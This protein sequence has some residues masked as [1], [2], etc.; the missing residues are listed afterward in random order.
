MNNDFIVTEVLM[1]DRFDEKSTYSD[2]LDP[3]GMIL[4]PLIFRFQTI[5]QAGAL[6][7]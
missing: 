6:K 5:F 2:V 4:H 1:G 3:N 7:N